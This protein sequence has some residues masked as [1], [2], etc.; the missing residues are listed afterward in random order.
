MLVSAAVTLG[1]ASDQLRW[2]K[3]LGVRAIWL[4][5]AGAGAELVGG[6]ANFQSDLGI[7]YFAYK[8]VHGVRKITCTRGNQHSQGR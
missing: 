5:L 3:E 8:F 7:I 4:T 6:I 1:P 2:A